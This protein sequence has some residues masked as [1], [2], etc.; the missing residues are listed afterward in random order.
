MFITGFIDH[1]TGY[2]TQKQQ[3]ELLASSFV[4]DQ[5]RRQQEY[6]TLQHKHDET[7]HKLQQL[8]AWQQSI[9]MRHEH[10]LEGSPKVVQRLDQR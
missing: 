5:Q 6:A 4:Q 9:I 8:E 10:S 2:W 3:L 1:M 7:R